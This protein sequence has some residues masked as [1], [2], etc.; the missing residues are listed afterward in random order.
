MPDEPTMTDRDPDDGSTHVERVNPDDKA[1]APVSPDGRRPYRLTQMAKSGDAI[2][3]AGT[4]VMLLPEEVKDHHEMV[5]DEPEPVPVPVSHA[6]P[7]P[8][9]MIAREPR[10]DGLTPI[11]PPHE[12]EPAPT[13][14]REHPEESDLEY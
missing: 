9:Q 14:V 3:P 10:D 8:P 11:E 13:V 4:V 6:P 7:V 5:P 2:L 12:P 1:A